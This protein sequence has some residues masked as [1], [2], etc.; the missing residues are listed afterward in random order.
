MSTDSDS[1]PD[2]NKSAHRHAGASA[3]N[4]EKRR[5]DRGAR[6][7]ACSSRNPFPP[8]AWFNWWTWL[9]LGAIGLAG[10]IVS[11]LSDRQERA[12]AVAAMFHEEHNPNLI[13]D[14]KSCVTNLIALCKYYHRPAR[15][16]R[17]DE[18]RGS[19]RTHRQ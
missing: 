5:V 11:T 8:S 1:Q 16:Q 7:G 10:V 6:A 9:A 18:D 17:R 15:S 2:R 12:Q 4:A 3:D 19:A 13:K 14:K